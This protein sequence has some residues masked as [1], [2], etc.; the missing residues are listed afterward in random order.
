MLAHIGW[1]GAALL[2]TVPPPNV[3]ALIVL[4]L[5]NTAMEAVQ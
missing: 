2:G 4:E 5:L 3:L 1:A